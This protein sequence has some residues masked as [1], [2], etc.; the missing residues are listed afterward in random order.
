VTTIQ[1]NPSWNPYNG[2]IRSNVTY[3]HN[4]WVPYVRLAPPNGLASRLLTMSSQIKAISQV[5][6]RNQITE[7]GPIILVQVENEYYNG[8]A[9]FESY[10]LG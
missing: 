3:Y 10:S 7:G 8:G 6:A 4:A 2:E 9:Y 1:G 5:I